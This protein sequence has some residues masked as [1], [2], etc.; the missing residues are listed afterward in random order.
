MRVSRDVVDDRQA[1]AEP[2]RGLDRVGQ[3]GAK[4]VAPLLGDLRDHEPVDHGLDR[5]HLVA[6]E[7]DLFVDVAHA[8]IDPHT[9][10]SGLAHVLK[11][12]LVMPLAVLDQRR[13]HLEAGAGRHPQHCV[14]D[15]VGRLFGNRPAALGTV[16]HADA[17]VQE[18][19][20][21]IDLGDSAD[22]RARVVRRSPLVDGDGRR[23]PLDL[24]H[25]RL[26]HLPQ[27]LARVGREALDI[28]PLPLGVDGIERQR[29]F[30]R[31]RDPGH[32]DHLVARN[33]DGDVL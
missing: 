21:V 26:F 23:E 16:G 27:E 29:R 30:T 10:E 13:Q 6:V 12:R 31:P 33:L 1:I 4:A 15:L 32:D 7:L 28:A 11:D 8:A 14:D 5:V 22:G 19:Q 24:V 25:V 20:V 2:Q 3:A 18:P 17:G 9:H